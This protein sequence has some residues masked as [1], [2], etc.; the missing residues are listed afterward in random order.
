MGLEH[1]P[2]VGLLHTHD[3]VG[4]LRPPGLAEDGFHLGILAERPFDPCRDRHRILE[5]SAGQT[6]DLDEQ[7]PFVEPWHE[8]GP[9]IRRHRNAGRH[10]AGGQQ[11]HDHR[12]EDGQLRQRMV[13]PMKQPHQQRLVL[14]LA[15]QHR[16]RQHRHERERDDQ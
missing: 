3:V 5:R 11:R 1:H 12:V 2:D 9:E 7:I 6:G 8:L 13:G 14:L 15:G 16:R 4:D 10:E